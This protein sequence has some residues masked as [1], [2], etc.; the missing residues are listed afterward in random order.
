[1]ITVDYII[2]NEDRHFGNFG[3]LRNGDTLEWLGAAPIFDS[4]SSLG[5]DFSTPEI[6][7]DTAIRNRPFR[8]K[9]DEQLELVSSFD[10]LDFHCLT[11]LSDEVM[12]ILDGAGYR[13]DRARSQA[14]ASAVERR[15]KKVEGLALQKAGIRSFQQRL[16]AASE[17][18]R[19]H[20]EAGHI[21]QPG[22]DDR[23][24]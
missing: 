2:A 16:D 7:A 4:G 11:G 22:K 13:I 20:N 1:M 6:E 15:V 5:F 19:E 18:A 9:A 23:T 14:I 3:L 12:S 10:W 17:R 21:S 8:V 24:L